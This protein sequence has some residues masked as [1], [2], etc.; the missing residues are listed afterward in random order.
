MRPIGFGLSCNLLA[1]KRWRAR[2]RG[3][4]QKTNDCLILFRNMKKRKIK[5]YKLQSGESGLHGTPIKFRAF[6]GVKDKIRII[7][8]RAKLKS[9]SS[10]CKSGCPDFPGHAAQ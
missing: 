10:Q 3:G 6:P 7:L 5:P 2:E 9:Q 1:L 8:I 4:F